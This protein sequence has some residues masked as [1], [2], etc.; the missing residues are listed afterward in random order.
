LH[1]SKKSCTFAANFEKRK[2]YYAM[3]STHNELQKP[4][5]FGQAIGV[6]HFIGRER[7]LKRLTANFSHG[8]NTILMAPRRW[9]KTSL[10][11]RTMSEIKN[12]YIKVIYI[13]AYFCRNEYDFYN[14]FAE[15]ILHQTN[16]KFEQ[17]AE[18]AGEFLMRLTPKISYNLP[19]AEEYSVSLGITPRT[20]QPEEILQLPEIIA[21][22]K[23][24]HLMI[25]IDEFQQIGEFTDS[26]TV[27]KRMRSVWQH[28]EHVNYC[29]FGSKKHLL[30]N[31]FLKS[32]YPFY[33]FGDII[34]LDPIEEKTWLPY[35]QQGFK[36]WGKNISEDIARQLCQKV[37]LH[38]SYIQQ[39]AWLT[40]LNTDSEA[41]ES[42]LLQGL[43]DLINENSALFIQQ[44]EHLTPYQL[45]FLYAMLDGI[46]SDFAKE[47]IREQYQLGSYSNIA[48][49]KTALIE[50]E[51]IDTY[52]GAVVFADPVFVLWMRRNMNQ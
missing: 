52:K 14:H 13:D 15:C 6:N 39:L 51:L 38:P 18:T 28:Q 24:I 36:S 47:D 10:V 33:K 44:T 37:Q 42:T 20:H 31:M 26:M 32:S 48:R 4:F 43:D 12:D 16:S 40:L 8:I 34:P 30:Q 49:I 41:T 45:N 35:L 3:K 25:C 1:I 22:R 5:V 19:S 11:K 23:N 27:Q 29:L 9:G 46:T 50:K 2:L 17:W 7:E 21:Q